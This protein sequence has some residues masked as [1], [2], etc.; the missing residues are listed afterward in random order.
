MNVATAASASTAAAYAPGPAPPS[1]AVPNPSTPTTAHTSQDAWCG[2]VSP[3]QHVGEVVTSGHGDY[4]R[5]CRAQHRPHLVPLLEHES[6]R[7]TSDTPRRAAVVRPPSRA[8][9]RRSHALSGTVA[10]PSSARAATF[11]AA[12][13]HVGEDIHERITHTRWC[14]RDRSNPRRHAHGVTNRN[15]GRSRSYVQRPHCDDRGHERQR[16]HH[17]HHRP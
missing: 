17:R 11:S 4:Q 5:T 9:R 3:T 14:R 12:T 1:S 6:G 7:R 13:T 2:R 15:R 16:P 10:W 8:P